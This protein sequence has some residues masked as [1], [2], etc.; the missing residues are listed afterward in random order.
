MTLIQLGT[1]NSNA[2]SMAKLK[3]LS[4]KMLISLIYFKK[5]QVVPNMKFYH[6]HYLLIKLRFLV[7]MKI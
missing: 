7:K 6:I 5:F 1:I 3:L 4:S 2:L